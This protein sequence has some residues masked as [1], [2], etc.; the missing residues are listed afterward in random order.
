MSSSRASVAALAILSATISMAAQAPVRQALRGQGQAPAAGTGLVTGR[1]VAG[2]T[3]TP[4][5]A[6]I[7]T[8]NGG[9]RP[10][11]LAPRVL[12]D[13]NGRFFFSG[14]AAGHYTIGAL[15]P[16]WLP[17]T[18]GQRRPGESSLSLDLGD[19]ER[20]GQIDVPLWR[21]AVISGHVVDETGDP[22]VGF[23]VR[24]V[25]ET[26]IAGRLRPTSTAR[27]MTDDRGAFRFFDLAPGDYLIAVPA[28]VTSEPASLAGAARAQGGMPHAY[29]QTMTDVGAA[30]MN[31]ERAQAVAG[32]DHTLVEG[33]SSLPGTPPADGAWRTYPTTFYPSATSVGAATVVHAVS[34]EVQSG[35]DVVVHLTAT[36]EI[37]GT[38]AGDDGP[39][40]YHAV[41]LL[42]ADSADVPLFDVATAVTDAS[43]RFTFFGVP[44]G[45]Y[46]ARVIRVPWPGGNLAFGLVGGTGA[47]KRILMVGR[48]PMNGPPAP[49]AGPL[50]YV[51]QPVTVAERNVE[52]LDLRLR[53]GAR[54]TGRAQFDGSAPHPTPA[55]WS[56][57]RVSLE[58]ANGRSSAV[59]FPASFSAD[60]QFATPSTWPGRYLLRAMAPPGWT[61]AGATYQG[62]DISDTPFDLTADISDVVIAYT[63]HPDHITG[64]VQGLDGQP[65]TNYVA[66]LFPADPAGWTDYG[67]T[68]R[69]VRS[70]RV[71]AAG[72][73]TLPAPPPGQYC[74]LAIPENEADGWQNPAT[75]ARL[76][77]GADRIQVRE[78]EPLAVTLQV[79]KGP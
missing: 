19:G 64:T 51:S 7:V 16:G 10:S 29:L 13:D 17:G 78:G 45:Q 5:P 73:F 3:D 46:V 14:L 24:V 50:L 60:G 28:T 15:K 44:A 70:V 52:N 77:A 38:V 32:S 49:P 40:A 63:D 30:P 59:S 27:V 62:R 21:P 53:T 48:G 57:V 76:S 39:A 41:H 47:I 55:Q 33:V 23:D 56:A 37:S 4:V 58:P 72:T 22:L 66:L 35:I 74:L 26:F 18:Y 1:V 2:T 65:G 42:P 36:H 43:G 69:R 12:T 25:H 9:G 31:F 54:V 20:R 8:L 6:A 71:S 67:R 75:L 34:G 68:S 79:R 61:F 11:R